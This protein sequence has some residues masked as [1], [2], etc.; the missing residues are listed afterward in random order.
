M[1]LTFAVFKARNA[2]PQYNELG[3]MYGFYYYSFFKLFHF[4]RF[5]FCFSTI[6]L[7]LDYLNGLSKPLKAL[8][9]FISVHILIRGS[10]VA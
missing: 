7:I 2:T 8:V 9:G 4:P 1:A 6:D 3:A 10:T 5:S